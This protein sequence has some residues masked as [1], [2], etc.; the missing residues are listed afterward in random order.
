MP[1]TTSLL[2]P[3]S[4]LLAANTHSCAKP[5]VQSPDASAH[6][7]AATAQHHSRALPS[8]KSFYARSKKKLPNSK[9]MSSEGS[10][11]PTSSRSYH[12]TCVIAS[13]N[14]QPTELTRFLFVFFKPAGYERGKPRNDMS[15]Q[16]YGVQNGP[17]YILNNQQSAACGLSAFIATVWS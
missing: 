10:A 2:S 3:S 14:F 1:A 11:N 9:N 16:G 8:R 15:L 12:S 5:S 17:K 7:N 13:Q 6:K 4:A